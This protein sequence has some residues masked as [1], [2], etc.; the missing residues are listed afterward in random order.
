MEIGHGQQ[1]GP[2]GRPATPW[3]RRPGTSGRA[4]CDKSCRRCA[5]GRRPRSV[6]HDRPAPP[7]GSARSPRCPSVGRG[8][9]AGMGGTPSR[10]AVAE[11]GPPP[12]PPAVTTAAR[13]AVS[14]PRSAG[15]RAGWSPR[16][17]SSSGL[18]TTGRRRGSRVDATS[19]ARSLRFSV[20]LKKNRMAL[21][22]AMTVSAF[23]PI[24][25]SAAGSDRRP[26][27]WLCRETSR[28]VRTAFEVADIVALSLA[29]KPADR[30]AVDQ[31]LA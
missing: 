8:S 2:G 15:G 18:R 23:V 31:P 20:T 5:G 26:P 17:P 12:R 28:R 6:R 25:A 27:Q 4:G 16:R 7:F 24:D 29:A 30:L 22:L 21:A 14:S 3:Q 10:S 9:L 19:W 11:D 1:F 13:Y